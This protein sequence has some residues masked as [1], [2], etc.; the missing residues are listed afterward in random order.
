[1]RFGD[2]DVPG[3]T[4]ATTSM[5]AAITAGTSEGLELAL[6][7]IV[8]EDEAVLEAWAPRGGGCRVLLTARRAEWRPELGVRAVALGILQLVTSGRL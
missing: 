4:A 3:H 7:A 6:T 5:M 8:N 2:H 1:M